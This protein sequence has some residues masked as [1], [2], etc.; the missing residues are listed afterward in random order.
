M[1]DS[2]NYKF[3]TL[4]IHAGAAPDPTQLSRGVT[5]HRTTAY[6]FK[7]TE[8]AANLFA[9]KELGNVYSRIMNPTQAV[10]E[11]RVAA[12]EGG[13]AAL[14]LASGTAGVHYS[15]LTLASAGDNIVSAKDLYGGTFTMFDCI[16]PQIGI[17][18]KWV[19]PT[20]PENFA[21]AIDK[22]TR[23]IFI[24]SCGN[25]ALNV[26]DFDAIA[27]IAKAHN[28]P[29]IC[30][31]TF[32]TPYLFRPI[33]HGIDIVVH[34]LTKWMGGHGIGIGGAVVDSGRFD[35]KKS[36]HPLF[37]EPDP[38]YHGLRWA[39][40]LGDLL[41]LAYILRMRTVPLRNL[42]A[43]ISADNAW[44]FLQGIETL[45]LRM[46]RHCENGMAAAKFLKSHKSVEWVNY[47]GFE[48]HPTHAHAKKYFKGKYG[49]MMT[50]GIKGG[51][52]AASKFIESLKL[53]SHLANV[54]DAKSLAIHPWTTTHS[55]LTED[56]RRGAGISPEMVRLSI[57]IE[58]IDD[59]TGDIDQALRAATK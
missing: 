36:G 58:H 30:D 4:A 17:G 45:P 35:W 29:V 22:K 20:N 28:L 47:P 49:G 1:S 15:V 33:E 6:Q 37:N 32:T 42:G 9:L 24:E 27:D 46:D 40:D 23:A 56:Q 31:S 16:H 13:A 2:P 8:H 11:N 39:H 19:D 53:L 48:D 55:Q 3:E 10:L 7:S 41:P 43:C 54:G 14:A 5:L 59:I 12:L 21:K 34:S 51:A 26:P 52:G 50:F 18:T 25:P 38:N 57:G 44:M